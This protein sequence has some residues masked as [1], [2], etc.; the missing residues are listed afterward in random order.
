LET[1]AEMLGQARLGDPGAE[2][3]GLLKTLRLDQGAFGQILRL[4]YRD[5]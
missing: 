5:G 4:A 3:I 2:R 1:D